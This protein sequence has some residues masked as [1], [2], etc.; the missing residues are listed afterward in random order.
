MELCKS[1]IN[2]LGTS[3]PHGSLQLETDFFVGLFLWTFRVF[4]ILPIK[5]EALN[6]A[7]MQ[8]IGGEICPDAPEA[9][10]VI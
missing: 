7:G 4:K 10:S 5:F 3:I 6:V 8:L 1:S 2:L 9:E